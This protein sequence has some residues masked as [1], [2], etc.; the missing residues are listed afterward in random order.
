VAEASITLLKNDDD[1]LP[2]DKETLT[3]IAVIGPNAAEARIGGGGSSYLEPPT[4]VSP[5]DGLT[6]KLGDRVKIEYTRGCDN[7]PDQ[8]ITDAENEIAKAVELAKRADI[9]VIFAG[10][11]KGYESEGHD[12]PNMNLPGPQTELIKEVTGVNV[13]TVVV[14][15]CGA[16]VTMPWLD[17]VSAVLLAFYP[18]QEGGHAIAD[19]LM[20]DVNPSGKLSITLPTRYED[21]PAYLNYPGERNVYYGEGIFVGYRYYDYKGVVPMFPFGFGLSYTTFAYSDLKVPD[22]VKAGDAVEVAVTVKNTGERAGKEVVQLYVH[23]MLASVVR[24]PKELK[25]F[26]KVRLEPGEHTTLHFTL[27]ARAFSFYDVDQ[28]QWV[29]EPGEFEIL[30]GSS[31][32]D[33]RARATMTLK[34]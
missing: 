30:V 8:S 16:P 11:P 7:D 15:N 13:R 26:Q 34:A 4:R 22:V 29:V 14:L 25:G 33:I 17:D 21:N 31:S 2:L 23:D 6:A 9:A 3:T 10:M 28:K 27:D 18:G 1:V 12:R 20:G 5:L 32:R 24:P 19:I